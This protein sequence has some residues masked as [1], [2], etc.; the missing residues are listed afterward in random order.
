[1]VFLA[2]N[3]W[4]Y[5]LLLGLHSVQTVEVDQWHWERA[6]ALGIGQTLFYELGVFCPVVVLCA[7]VAVVGLFWTRLRPGR[8]RLQLWI[9]AG[10]FCLSSLAILPATGGKQ[11][12]PRYWLP[13]VPVIWLIAS[14]QLRQVA[15]LTPRPFAVIGVLLFAATIAIGGWVNTVG[16]TRRLFADYDQRVLPALRFL[17][18]RDER[19]VAV[20][21]QW[22]AQELEATFD[23]KRFF[24]TKNDQQLMQLARRLQS[25]G[26]SSFLSLRYRPAT[27]AVL[28]AP[29]LTV[30]RQY[31]GPYGS[32]MVF[33]CT[34]DASAPRGP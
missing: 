6:G 10:V 26:V 18:E 25:E 29:G 23:E 4:L 1:V 19:I 11:L 2:V 15:A 12:G 33:R 30:R 32:Y 14:L 17:R 5:G 16:G 27:T 22:I 24:R 28:R 3:Y 8:L 31:L 7:A 13:V 9:I 20:S 34:I 21:H